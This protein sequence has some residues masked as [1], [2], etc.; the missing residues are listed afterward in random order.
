MATGIIS[1]LQGSTT[2]ALVNKLLMPRF[3][4]FILVKPSHHRD[5]RGCN[6]RRLSETPERYRRRSPSPIRHRLQSRI[7]WC[8]G[9]THSRVQDPRRSHASRSLVRREITHSRVPQD[10]DQRDRSRRDTHSR[11]QHP[12]GRPTAGK[13]TLCDR[14]CPN[15]GRHWARMHAKKYK[16]Y[17][18]PFCKHGVSLHDKS[19]FRSHLA[20]HT[21][22]KI[23]IKQYLGDVPEGY[24]NALMCEMCD[25]PFRA[26]T[27]ADMAA[28]QAIAHPKPLSV[29]APDVLMAASTSMPSVSAGTQTSNPGIPELLE[30]AMYLME[31]DDPL[32]S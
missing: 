1:P 24:Y 18:C 2:V 14:Q 19:F 21:T 28:H 10:L 9:D 25:C 6:R 23:N 13:C 32:F 5:C 12:R 17:I 31:E 15:L 27:V 29:S 3:F 11:V 30:E 4:I 22:I 7:G 16:G 20:S 26:L 8:R